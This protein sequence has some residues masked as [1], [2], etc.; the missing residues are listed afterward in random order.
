[1]QVW[2]RAPLKKKIVA[3]ITDALKEVRPAGWALTQ[4]MTDKY[5]SIEGPDTEPV[6]RPGTDYFS[7]LVRH[8]NSGISYNL[9]L[10][11]PLLGGETGGCTGPRQQHLPQDGLEVQ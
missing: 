8:F 2:C 1:M 4:E 6:W 10:A 3:S 5:L 9:Y 11:C 7:K